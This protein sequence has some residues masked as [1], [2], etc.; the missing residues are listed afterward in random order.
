MDV[1]LIKVNKEEL[2]S[3]DNPN[4]GQL[5][6]EY[7]HLKRVKL[8]DDDPK[9]HLLLRVCTNQDEHQTMGWS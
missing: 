7:P 6:K 4:Y 8:E 9:A 5:L 1:N 3:V 2:L